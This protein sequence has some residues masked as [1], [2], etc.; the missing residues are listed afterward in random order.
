M[1][2]VYADD[3]ARQDDKFEG[4]V[5][6]VFNVKNNGVGYGKV[7]TTAPNRVALIAKLDTWAKRLARRG[8]AAA[9]RH[10]LTRRRRRERAD[11]AGPR[12]RPLAFRELHPCASAPA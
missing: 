10:R 12:A 8:E 6:G 1:S 9:E 2:G 7:S 5:D 11:G 4:G 3:R